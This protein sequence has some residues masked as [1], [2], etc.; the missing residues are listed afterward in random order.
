MEN[1]TFKID[2]MFFITKN[3]KED[4]F[5]KLYNNKFISKLKLRG[6]NK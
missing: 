6:M 2:N 1:R 4:M 5:D 3:S